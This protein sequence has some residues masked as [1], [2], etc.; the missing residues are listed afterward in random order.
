MI[1]SFFPGRIRLRAP[2]F[3]D[4][5]LVER[6]LSVIKKVPGFINIENNLVTGSVLIHYDP[7]K[8]PQ[9]KLLGLKDFFISLSNEA[10]NFDGSDRTKILKMLDEAELKLS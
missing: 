1:T 8:V 3:K 4:T 10:E 7:E 2:V 6:A 5:V 9:E